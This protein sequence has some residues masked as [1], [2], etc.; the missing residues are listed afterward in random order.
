[1]DLPRI[2]IATTRCK[3]IHF[4]HSVVYE[5]E[6]LFCH[7]T[8]GTLIDLPVSLPDDALA[9]KVKLPAIEEGLDLL[10]VSIMN[11][12]RAS[13]DFVANWR[14]R[15]KKVVVYFLDAWPCPSLADRLKSSF[16][17]E[18]DLLAVS[19]YESLPF[20]REHFSRVIWLP[21]AINPTRFYFNP[22]QR[23]IFCAAMGRQDEAFFS[24]MRQFCASRELLWVYQDII[25]RFR[26]SWEDSYD[27]YASFLRNAKYVL[28]WSG[29]T[30]RGNWATDF[31]IDPVTCRWFESA[32]AGCIPV[33]TPPDSPVFSALFPGM[34]VVD[35][36]NFNSEPKEVLAFLENHP[37]ENRQAHLERISRHVQSRHTWYHRVYAILAELGMEEH[38]NLP[39]TTIPLDLSAI[40]FP[41]DLVA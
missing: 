31:K 3:P 15:C 35:V 25:G 1:M 13:L 17:S 33:G 36:G 10:I 21:Q 34:Q 24:K 22:R 40:N 19:Y 5:F 16:V 2:G 32:A 30:M 7:A 6:D 14:K 29:K 23:H 12:G 28:N 18:V 37:E 41:R 11:P 38:F 27:L 20:Y 4:S 39:P 9:P 8:A 26:R